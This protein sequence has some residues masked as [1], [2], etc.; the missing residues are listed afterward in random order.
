L[1]RAWNPSRSPRPLHEPAA[2][3]HQAVESGVHNLSTCPNEVKRRCQSARR[4]FPRTSPASATVDG[5]SEQGDGRVAADADETTRSTPTTRRFWGSR[6]AEPKE[7]GSSRSSPSQVRR[8]PR[9][10][11]RTAGMPR[12]PL[13]EASDAPDIGGVLGLEGVTAC[14]T[15]HRPGLQRRFM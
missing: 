4:A 8:E 3:D 15:H 10:E 6:D 11:D 2:G 1:G 9:P 13:L 7:V 5:G 12:V 14:L